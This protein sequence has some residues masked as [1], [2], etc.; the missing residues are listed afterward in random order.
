MAEGASEAVELLAAELGVTPV[1]AQ[2]HQRS[3]DP[4]VVRFVS[5]AATVQYAGSR[6][7]FEQEA[8]NDVL[9]AAKGQAGLTDPDEHRWAAAQA[10]ASVELHEARAA[11]LDQ[12]RAMVDELLD[13]GLV[14]RS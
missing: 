12:A 6:G 7:A 11:A 1:W 3:A 9:D 5:L 8:V 14:Q 10:A 2:L 4:A 13:L